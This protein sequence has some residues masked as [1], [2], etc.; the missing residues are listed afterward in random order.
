MAEMVAA[1]GAK[2]AY[3]NLGGYVNDTVRDKVA[4]GTLNADNQAGIVHSMAENIHSNVKGD[5]VEFMTDPQADITINEIEG[6]VEAELSKQ[7]ADS[8]HPHAM[9][10]SREARSSSP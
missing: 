5:R 8:G 3:V 9:A 1:R 6:L 7:L 4:S 2:P 10:P